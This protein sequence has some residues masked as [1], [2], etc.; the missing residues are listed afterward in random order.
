[1]ARVSI[2]DIATSLGVSHATVSMA[3]RGDLR[4]SELRRAQVA[5]AAKRMGYRPDPVLSAFLHYRWHRRRPDIRASLAWLNFW[6]RPSEL[7]N[8]HELDAYWRGAEATAER[9][10]YR[11]E[12]VCWDGSKPMARLNDILKARNVAGLLVAPTGGYPVADG[13]NWDDFHFVRFGYSLKCAAGHVVSSDQLGD[14]LLAFE[15]MRRAGYIRIGF[16]RSTAAFTRFAAG[17]TLGQLSLAPAE[18][19]PCIG[20]PAIGG[21]Q[22]LRDW[23]EAHRPDAIF[24]DVP[25]MRARLSRMGLRVPEDIG[26]GVSSVLDCDAD[27]GINQ[28]SEEIG[29]VAVQTLI[30][31]INDNQRGIP[32]HPREVLV[33]GEWV[34]G[35]S[36]PVKS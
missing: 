2:R 3:L 30:S 21:E 36:L 18:Q 24:T 28:N 8:F 12:A 33:T 34:D 4:I 1:M 27:A 26:L 10:G 5:A 23:I 32:R 9:H 25:D 6:P 35:A 13:L 7:R 14:A 29:R 15:R 19:V 31:L 20:L 11:L 16:V 17:V 22:V